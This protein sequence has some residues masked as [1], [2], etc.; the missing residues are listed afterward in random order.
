[1]LSIRAFGLKNLRIA[2]GISDSFSRL[3]YFFIPLSV[4]PFGI[5]DEF[6]LL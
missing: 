4:R 3:N 2:N 6:I 1:M 5:T